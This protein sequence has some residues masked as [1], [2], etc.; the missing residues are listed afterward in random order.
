MSAASYARIT[1]ANGRIRV[2]VVGVNSRGGAHIDAVNKDPRATV[3][4]IC[5]VDT[6][7][8]EKAMEFARKG[9]NEPKAVRDFRKLVEMNDL[10]VITIATPEHWHAPMAIMGVL[11]GKH[12]YLEKP[13]SHNI[14]ENDL[15]LRACKKSG[16][17]IQMGNQQRSSATS[18]QAI[19]EIREGLIGSVYHGRAWYA[20][21]R[22]SIGYGK[23]V[24]V[25]EHLDW[26]LWQGPAPRRDYRDNIVHY[27]W[28]WFKH[29]GTGEVLNNGLHEYDIC[30]WAMG[31]GYPEEV[32]S[33]GGRFF[34]QD[35]WEF[36]DHQHVVF[37]YPG[38]RIITW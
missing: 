28:H 3:S 7:V 12:V 35:D 36:F 6:L 10:D 18:T 4:H 30:R 23:A 1:G 13:S 32:E 19:Q 34:F 8:L 37:K 27:N 16:K 24:G 38:G 20:A 29:W 21:T 9:G 14:H 33:S 2:A 31:L 15:I 25:P 11:A 22:G 5:D 17:L 26:E